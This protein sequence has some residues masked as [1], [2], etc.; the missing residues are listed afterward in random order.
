MFLIRLTNPKTIS[1]GID[2]MYGWD[3]LVATV[4]SLSIAMRPCVN[5]CRQGKA[6]PESHAFVNNSNLLGY[7]TSWIMQPFE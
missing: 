5:M 2:V 3:A 6:Y 7:D 4:E 1:V